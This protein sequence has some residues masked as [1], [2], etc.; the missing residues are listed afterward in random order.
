MLIKCKKIHHLITNLRGSAFLALTNKKSSSYFL[1]PASI[2]NN[3]SKS[4]LPMLSWVFGWGDEKND[5]E[6]THNNNNID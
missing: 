3:N 1:T 4:H 6:S 5:N 2:K